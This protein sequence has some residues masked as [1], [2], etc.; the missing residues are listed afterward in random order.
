MLAILLALST[1][2]PRL[3]GGMAV[4]HRRDRLHLAMG[5]AGGALIGVACFE[6]LPEA[7]ELISAG[8]V[9]AACLV[10]VGAFA[11]LERTAFAHVHR[12]DKACNPRA[13][14]IGAG[15]ITL[16][17]FIDGLAIGAAFQISAEVGAIISAAVLLHAFADGLNTVTTVLRH[18]LGR[19]KAIAWLVANAAAP[20]AGA[21]LG[22]FATLPDAV[23]GA[24]LAF[25]A[26]MFIY[27]G[28]GSLVPEAHRTGRDRGI[29]WLA[30]ATGLA[31][32]I[33]AW[34]LT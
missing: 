3:L 7:V 17:A 21:A 34:R 6:T 15:G 9:A 8:A 13:G 25:F 18:G 1:A 5:F 14:H 32:A 4:L 26:G 11:V 23:L 20:A 12:E 10:G 30:T 24:M 16:H 2:G 19:P 29:V 31:L 27:L 33:V 28:A 22:L